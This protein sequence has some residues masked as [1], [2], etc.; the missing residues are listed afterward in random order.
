MTSK[1]GTL[2]GTPKQLRDTWGEKSL[3]W[4]LL[5]LAGS[6]L[7]YFHAAELIA[8]YYSLDVQLDDA[9]NVSGVEHEKAFTNMLATAERNA[10]ADDC[11]Q[12]PHAHLPDE[13][14]NRHALL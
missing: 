5:S 4:G 9:R 10:R 7:A 8:R 3:P 2:D 13:P 11:A 12:R 6:E 1:L 14:G